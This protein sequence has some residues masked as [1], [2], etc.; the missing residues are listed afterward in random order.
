MP[1]QIL[2]KDEVTDRFGKRGWTPNELVG[3]L[4]Y[5]SGIPD[6]DGLRDPGM[7]MDVPMLTNLAHR[8]RGLLIEVIHK[9]SK[10]R[11]GI[12]YKDIAEVGIERAVK[13]VELKERSI[14]G[15]AFVGGLLLGPVGAVV[16][17][18]TGI[19]DGKLTKVPDAFVV[20]TTRL[21]DAIA[22]TCADKHVPQVE[23][24]LAGLGGKKA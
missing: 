8:D 3:K 2:S 18:M 9:F 12:D 21:G 13:I 19:K 16:G 4:N 1:L 17:G 14:I 7:W 6:V 10:H 20:I 24:F 23:R 15:R 5:A 22:F 11:A